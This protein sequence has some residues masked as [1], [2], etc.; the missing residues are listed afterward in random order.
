MLTMSRPQYLNPA[1]ESVRKQSFTNWEL[2]IV[3]DGDDPRIASV[4]R[5]WTEHDARIRYFHRP[6]PGNIA[7]AMNY[8]IAQSAGHFIA[9]LD[10]DD[11]WI[12]PT[13]MEMQHEFLLSH[14]D[15]DCVGGGAVVVDG[16]GRERMHY[17]KPAEPDA[18]RACALL[19]NPIIHSTAMFRKEAARAVGFYDE[20]LAGY[21]DWDLWLKIMRLGRVANLA[22]YFVTYRIWDGGGTSRN[23]M[24]NAWS[25]FRIVN[26]HRKYFPKYRM[27]VA[28]AVGYLVFATLPRAV[29]RRSYQS[30]ARF[31]KK[32][33]STQ[34]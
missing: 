1:I 25:G 29:R 10:D 12:V 6:V 7:N 15:I 11:A 34:N 4:V 21:Q 18:C 26:R 9:V 17:C 13:K 5:P 14:P 20:S 8:G 2:I 32:F 27:A 24:N 16:E 19:A 33:F 23:V 22:E 31:K 3:H 28:T 30:L